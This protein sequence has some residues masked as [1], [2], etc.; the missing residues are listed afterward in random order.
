[1]LKMFGIDIIKVLISYRRLADVFTSLNRR[2]TLIILSIVTLI[3]M[4]SSS[5]SSTAARDM[6]TMT[7]SNLFQDTYQ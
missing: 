2:N 6:M 1:V 4:D 7:K 3:P 5:Y